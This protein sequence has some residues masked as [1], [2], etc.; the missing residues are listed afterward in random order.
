MAAGH[1]GEPSEKLHAGTAPLPGLP[2]EAASSGREPASADVAQTVV[3]ATLDPRLHRALR[4]LSEEDVALLILVVLEDFTIADAAAVLGLSPGGAKTRLHR[5]R[6]RIR[7]TL[8]DFQIAYD[9]T[10]GP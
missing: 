5:A 8:S 6:Q 7:K 1:D 2:G 4:Q 3:D 9:Q 10:G